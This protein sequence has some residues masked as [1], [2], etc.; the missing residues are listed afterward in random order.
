[1]MREGAHPT[2][3]AVGQF[4]GSAL[5]PAGVI[6]DVAKGASLAGKAIKGAIAGGVIGGAQGASDA[7]D[8]TNVQDTSQRTLQGAQT[9][10][11]FGAALPA[12]GTAAGATYRAVAPFLGATSA[13]GMGRVASG[14]LA[15][16]MSPNTAARLG[17]L[18]D[19]GMLADASPAM[20]GL[21]QGVASKGGP[22]ADTVVDALSN[23]AGGQSN[24]LISTLEQ[25]LGP[26]YSPR[27]VAQMM[28]SK[29]DAAGPMFEDAINNGPGRVDISPVMQQFE[30]A[31][32]YAKGTDAARLDRAGVLLQGPERIG[33]INQPKYDPRALQRSKMEMDAQIAG[34]N[35]QTGSA[36]A[37]ATRDLVGV[38]SAL[39]NQLEQQVPNYADANLA[40][41]TAARGNEAFDAGRQAL[42]PGQDVLWPQDLAADFNNR[43]LEQ[44]ALMRAGARSDIASS[45]GINPNDLGALHKIVGGENDFNRAKMSTLFGDQST[46]NVVRDVG[47][48]RTYADTYNK[49]AQ[50][51]QTAQRAGNAQ[52]ISTAEM[53]TPT[54]IPKNL[55]PL[56]MVGNAGEYMVRKGFGALA[57]ASG[58]TARDQLARALISPAPVAQTNIQELARALMDHNQTA[59]A[60][61]NAGSSPALLAA[62]LT[63]Y[64]R[65]TQ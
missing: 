16:A 39:N 41:R 60:I 46:Q 38:R 21:T 17:T 4:V 5:A 53:P 64:R 28:N 1:M 45:L 59:N 23:R 30:N 22:A 25:N 52:A 8:L 20:L 27:E 48:E 62:A 55:T 47:N 11:A 44:Q 26:A 9:G 6:G 12:L 24:R 32:L 36:A 57:K 51:S 65:A 18:G 34:V 15:N 33:G 13:D 7:P 49:V 43:P 19:N 3:E 40:F 31:R 54:L 2:G 58:D 37:T 56:G 42:K 63:G 50:G 14:L 35:N 10:A 61:T 29:M